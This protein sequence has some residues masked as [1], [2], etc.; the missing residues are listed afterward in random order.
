[1]HIQ[2][3]FPGR[4]RMHCKENAFS[5]VMKHST[6]ANFADLYSFDYKVP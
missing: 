5:K 2:I 1:M 3:D 6:F 4:Y